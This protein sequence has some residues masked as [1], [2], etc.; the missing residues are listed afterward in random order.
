MT[1]GWQLAF[2]LLIVFVVLEG[3]AIGRHLFHRREQL[4]G[5]YEVA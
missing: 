3:I 1:L 2:V 5:P 4:D